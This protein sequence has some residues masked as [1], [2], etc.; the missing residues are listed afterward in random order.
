MKMFYDCHK[1]IKD[2][3]DEEASFARMAMIREHLK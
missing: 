2:G 3:E 1:K